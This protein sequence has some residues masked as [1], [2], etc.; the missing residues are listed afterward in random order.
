MCL[1]QVCNVTATV[2]HKYGFLRALDAVGF[3]AT[4]AKAKVVFVDALFTLI[5]V[6]GP[7]LIVRYA[8]NFVA[9]LD[10][11]PICWYSI[12]TNNGDFYEKTCKIRKS[13]PIA[14]LVGSKLRQCSGFV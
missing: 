13:N 6:H 4:A 12:S 5:T 3:F 11:L 7:L 10:L 1:R 2:A 14:I 9:T 8:T